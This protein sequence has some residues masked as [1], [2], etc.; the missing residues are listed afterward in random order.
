MTWWQ[1]IIAVAVGYGLGL[2]TN[3]LNERKG[4]P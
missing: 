1:A 3:Y 4:R 2:L